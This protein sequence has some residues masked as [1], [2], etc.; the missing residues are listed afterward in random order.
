MWLFTSTVSKTVNNVN[1]DPN[2]NNENKYLKDYSLRF[3][4]LKNIFLFWICLSSLSI[5]SLKLMSDISVLTSS[6]VSPSI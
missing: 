5:Y 1:K 6:V 4:F 2:K 3:L